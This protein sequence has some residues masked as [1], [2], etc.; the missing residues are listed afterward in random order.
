MTSN[1]DC[2][3]RIHYLTVFFK[4]SIPFS[5]TFMIIILGTSDLLCNKYVFVKYVYPFSIGR[6]YL[7]PFHVLGSIEPHTSVWRLSRGRFVFS[8]SF[9]KLYLSNLD[10]VHNSNILSI[11]KISFWSKSKPSTIWLSFF[12]TDTITWPNLR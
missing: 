1:Y 3:T 7:L 5:L 11:S 2:C 12:R 8:W 10:L 6:K 4:P 9:L